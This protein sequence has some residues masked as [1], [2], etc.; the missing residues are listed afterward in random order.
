[1][2]SIQH[3]KIFSVGIVIGLILSAPSH[4]AWT[5][6]GGSSIAPTIA[7]GGTVIPYKEVTFS[8]QMPGQVTFL[9]GKE[10]DKFKA[11]DVLVRIDD[12]ELLAK[13]G[14]IIAQ[15][16]SAQANLENARIQSVREQRSPQSRKGMSGMGMPSLFDDMF[17]KPASDM[18]G[19]TDPDFDRT[20]DRFNAMTQIRQAENGIRQAQSELTALDVKL[21]NTRSI[22]PFDGMIMQKFIEQDDIVQPGMP[23]LKFADIQ[24]LQVSVDVPAR[25]RPGLKKGAKID[26]EFDVS[27]KRVQVRIAQIYP[28]ADA[29][30]HTI[31]VKFDVP[32]GV[33]SPG[34]YA[35]VFVPDVS[36]GTRE[37]ATIPT[38]AILYNGSLPSVYVKGSDGKKSLRLI[39]V[40]ESKEK[41][42]TSYTTIL[43]GL[44]IG[45]TVWDD[46]KNMDGID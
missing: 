18:M 40:G 17:T 39:R 24:Y 26:A 11:G 9:A 29:E 5:T 28:M 10:G 12:S 13:R 19:R 16:R 32:I 15:Y 21:R 46:A 7:L 6:V 35:K 37:T 30:R 43:S 34:M 25:I 33:S 45:Q 3:N 27:N 23:L 8:A 36:G 42:G 22:A 4:A 44:R 20:A 31:K 1:M 14:V 2:G 41:D 38:A